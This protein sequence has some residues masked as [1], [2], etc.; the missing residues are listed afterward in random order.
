MQQCPVPAVLAY[1]AIIDNYM[2][3]LSL[4]GLRTLSKQLRVP[5]VPSVPSCFRLTHARRP[6]CVTRYCCENVVCPVNGRLHS[7]NVGNDVPLHAS[8]VKP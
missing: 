2:P 6:T 7:E 5:C 8:Q 1:L 4:C 3:F